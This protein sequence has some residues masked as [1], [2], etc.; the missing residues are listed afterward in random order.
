M[1]IE[2]LTKYEDREFRLIGVRFYN[3]ENE[4]EFGVNIQ[5]IKL[6]KDIN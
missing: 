1:V 3:Q 6:K 5:R 4:N 2:D